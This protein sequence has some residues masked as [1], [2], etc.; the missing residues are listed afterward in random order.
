MRFAIIP[1]IASVP[2]LI[3]IVVDAP[4]LIYSPQRMTEGFYLFKKFILKIRSIEAFVLKQK[5][6]S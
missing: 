4:L 1:D 6:Y 2:M 3:G 5:T